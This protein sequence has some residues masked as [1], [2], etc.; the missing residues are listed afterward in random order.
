MPTVPRSRWRVA[1]VLVVV[2]IALVHIAAVTLAALPPNRYSAHA[3]GLTSYLRPYF[4]Q[5]WR[6]FAPNP[7]AEDRFVRFQ[8]AY[9]VADGS[10]QTTPWVD[11]SDVELD[12]IRHQLIGGR[13]GYVTSKLSSPLSVRYRALGRDGRT[14][15][16]G[17]DPSGV[18]TWTELRSSLLDAGN[19]S[20]AV[21]LYLLY[22]KA[23]T[24][25]ATDVLH[26]RWPDRH[27][28]AVRYAQRSHGVTPFDDRHGSEAEREQARPDVVDR[29]NGW[30]EP[31]RGTSAE[32]RSVAQFDRRHR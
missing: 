3:T 24:R 11:W 21:G 22:D 17:D 26:A 30:R 15:V 28:V 8:G 6:L 1:G 14:L 2:V 19:T 20:R 23:A 16:S 5:N 10:V 29:V 7:V 25:L 31:I 13:A 18:E 4:A 12:V 32:R 27:W 9:T